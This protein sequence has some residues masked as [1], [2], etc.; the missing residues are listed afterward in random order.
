MKRTKQIHDMQVKVLL[1]LYDITLCTMKN[2]H[3]LPREYRFALTQETE[4]CKITV[5]FQ[6]HGN[7]GGGVKF[8]EYGLEA[9]IQEYGVSENEAGG[10]AF[11]GTFT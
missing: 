1:Q 3:N 9:G 5:M 2:I 10:V 8:G 4:I 6:V 11:A 7:R